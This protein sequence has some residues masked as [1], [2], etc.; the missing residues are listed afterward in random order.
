MII[1]PENIEEIRQNLM[2]GI[3]E[4]R[5]G[6]LSN[7]RKLREYYKGE[8][9]NLSLIET[10]MWEAVYRERKGQLSKA[11]VLHNRILRKLAKENEEQS[12]AIAKYNAAICYKKMGNY[13]ITLK[14]L[15]EAKE[16]LSNLNI[17]DYD[18][19]FY[20]FYA[21]IYADIY[22][23]DDAI[24]SAKKALKIFKIEKNDFE[25]AKT[26]CTLAWI[27][28]DKKKFNTAEKLLQEALKQFNEQ[29]NSKIEKL[30]IG[31][32]YNFLAHLKLEQIR[33]NIA[34]IDIHNI[35]TLANNAIKIFR[36]YNDHLRAT[37]TN[38][39]LAESYLILKEYNKATDIYTQILKQYTSDEVPWLISQA[40]YGLGRVHIAKNNKKEAYNFYRKSILL[41]EET[42][43]SELGDWA[44]AFLSGERLEVYQKMV[45]L[46]LEEKHWNLA[47]DYIERAKS[48]TLLDLLQHS[49]VVLPEKELD[50]I[51]IKRIE[52]LKKEIY[53]KHNE[54]DDYEQGDTKADKKKSHNVNLLKRQINVLES[55][56][57]DLIQDLDK[58]IGWE[59]ANTHK[60]I[61]PTLKEIQNSLPKDTAL[62]EYYIL[63]GQVM[64]FLVTSENIIPYEQIAKLENV[65]NLQSAFERD[66][67]EIIN[68]SG[69][70]PAKYTYSRT[71]L[72]LKKLYNLLIPSELENQLSENDIK[73]LILI[74]HGKI[75]YRLPLHLLY[76]GHKYWIE[77]IAISYAPSAG[78]YK[79][80]TDK[81][82]N[83]NN[84][85]LAIGT[86]TEDKVG[87]WIQK[88]INSLD[89][90]YG[91]NIHT[92]IGKKATVK[93]VRRY[94]K[95]YGLLHFSCHGRWRE[96]NPYLSSLILHKS[97]LTVHDIYQLDLNCDLITLSACRTMRSKV[98]SGDELLGLVRGFFYAGT[99][100]L[101]AS[102]WDVDA[103]ATYYLMEKFYALL[104][105]G[106]STTEALQQ[107]QLDLQE[108]NK[109]KH[110]YYWGGF[111]LM[112][113]SK[114][115]KS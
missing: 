19:L 37:S 89:N 71:L 109:Y 17:A 59:Y 30:Q 67:E 91:E 2:R 61:V 58:N 56:Y 52:E 33:S 102:L 5:W 97:E 93:Q 107:A 18:A 38:L 72:I 8:K 55:T 24:R 90:I 65:T 16:I 49:L 48:R 96:D 73:H 86:T 51:L 104:K 68:A 43:P 15:N 22:L 95:D 25:S 10:L 81:S 70:N 111:V 34:D 9:D 31:E 85:I 28:I 75:L 74:P 106:L 40:Y 78:V 113:S 63:N 92:C 45:S 100:S 42:R 14:L 115:I 88:E 47:F 76:D 26:L 87:E 69:K 82:S 53:H 77:K 21:Q 103:E 11:A 39:E 101:L 4:I 54:I 108:D 94:A 80:C 50:P 27:Y 46:C 60:G 62:L 41:L 105:Y 12:L 35:Q 1:T 13:Y 112:G 6:I 110:P 20:T 29:G 66:I 114:L 23:L 3:L 7:L 64:M 32:C 84:K 36:E 79:F 99:K 98:I 44:R 57:S 83:K